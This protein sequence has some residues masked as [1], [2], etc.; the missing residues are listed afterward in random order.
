MIKKEDGLQ[1]WKTRSEDE[2][3]GETIV[4][5]LFTK[6]LQLERVK[7]N[8]LYQTIRRKECDGVV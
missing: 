4:L 6:L 5:I 7:Q 2:G 3:V 1:S 8:T